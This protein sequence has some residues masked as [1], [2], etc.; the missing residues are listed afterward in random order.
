MDPLQARFGPFRIDE[1]QARLERDGQAVELP[2]RSFQVLCELTRRAGQLVSKDTLLD[3]VWGHRHVN[4]AALKN[5]V[6]QV[7]QVLGDDARESVYI[8]TVA[9]RGYRFIAALDTA[10]APAPGATTPPLSL[11]AA[12]LAGRG[13][14]LAQLNSALAA[15]QRGQRQ[16]V[17]VTG[18]PGIGK[19]S[20]VDGFVAGAK[21]RA[22][23]GQCVEHYGG[24][25]PY[26]PVLEA[27]NALCRADGAA[28]LDLMRRAAPTWL[29]QLP[30][31][32]DE[33]DRRA[34]QQEAS[35]ATQ[36]RML[37]EF[38]ELV[39]RLTEAR[40]LLLVLED[41]HWSDHATV[42]LLGYLARRRGS[43]RLMLLGT[44]RPTDLILHE[45]PLGALRLELRPRRLCVEV[46]LELLS[47][48]ESAEYL[49]ARLGGPAPEDFVRG[50]YGHTA[51]LPLFTV[52]V[53]DELLASGQLRQVG[54]VW[55]FPGADA[56]AIPRSI[57]GIIEGQFDRLPAE[58][59]RV[60]AAASVGGVEFLHQ[61]LAHVLSCEPDALLGIL[62]DIARRLPWMTGGGADVGADGSVSA[63]FRF[64]HAVY[65][66][67]L[68]DG[69]P[70]PQRMQWH[71]RWAAA[72]QTAHVAKPAEVAAE[73]ALHFERAGAR[74]EA[75]VELAVVAAR[76]MARGAPAEA[77]RAARHGLRLGEGL[78]SPALE[79]ELR[80]LE[81]VALTRQHVI[82]APEVAAAFERAR[83]IGPTDGP[84]WQRTLHGCWWVHFA[85][86]ELAQAHDLAAEM[87]ALAE[88]RG[89]ASLRL[90]GLNA[91]GLV[92]MMT[93]ELKGARTHLEA[94]MAT[95]ATVAAGQAPTS[96]VQ[97]PALE[98]LLALVLVYW[99]I[100][101]PLRARAL[102]SQA[103]S[104][105]SASRHPLS[106]A[107][108]LYAASIFH[109]Q[110]AEYDEVLALTERLYALV[111]EYALPERLGGFAWLHGQALVAQG[112]VDAGLEEMARAARSAREAGLLGGMIG[113]YYHYALACRQSG[114]MP[115]ARE[116]IESGLAL[117]N[118]TGEGSLQA[119]LLGLK[120][121][122]L[123]A[124]GATAE[125]A[126]L[127][128][129]AIGKARAQGAAFHELQLLATAQSCAAP[130]A[131][132]MRLGALLALYE[133][134]P[135]PVIAS[136][137]ALHAAKH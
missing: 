42:Q 76:A 59:Q 82:A 116:A 58:H 97:D 50:L 71:R 16:L 114:R 33:Q 40:P 46:D 101:E 45:H 129:Q 54:G 120:A 83:Q 95:R 53:V 100:G 88:R 47:E 66:Q 99:T 77:L 117:A 85:R 79:Q 127:L 72:L 15:S 30:W 34:L 124:L 119:L 35:G 78:L 64:A 75:A 43:D 106:E 105:A 9:R 81:A 10:A 25:E 135:S 1:A 125:S 19:S 4:E 49:A 111:D 52:A 63:R 6:S 69:L 131:D 67:V 104:T 11:A 134:D 122:S 121:E 8:E 130:A 55:E 109:A 113:F 87:L 39:D 60:L 108:A 38:G 5:I 92:L 103:V 123:H 137:R 17:F 18:E 44:F 73:L 2:P 133:S 48:A 94:A 132:P 107:M 118:D 21:V 12:G 128:T 20:L 27:L 7:R 13:K 56:L 31:F 98:A 37:R 62:D 68:Y 29:L 22:A 61:P 90:A 110:A 24:A 89:D 86:A 26:L 70:A 57:A 41:L 32:V 28:V 80:S 23:F 74:T 91:L 112:R 93:G 126:D 65:R 51:G 96:F 84:A 14:A 3:A 102:A 36:D 115:D 136:A